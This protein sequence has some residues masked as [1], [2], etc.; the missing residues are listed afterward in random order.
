VAVRVLGT[1]FICL[2]YVKILLQKAMEYV[3]L[4]PVSV[5]RQK[6]SLAVYSLATCYFHGKIKLRKYGYCL[7]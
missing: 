3:A 6:N 5:L 7:S 1:L 4:F 2:Y